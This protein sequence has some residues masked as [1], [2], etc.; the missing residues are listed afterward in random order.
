MRR[1]R[2]Y[3]PPQS[4]KLQTR[5]VKRSERSTSNAISRRND[6]VFDDHSGQSYHEEKKEEF[7]E[8]S[9][10]PNVLRNHG[11]DWRDFMDES[12][13]SLLEQPSPAICAD[14][15][16][17]FFQDLEFLGL[18][19]GTDIQAAVGAL[20]ARKGRVVVTNPGTAHWLGRERSSR[21]TARA[22]PSFREGGFTK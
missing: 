5:L 10:I 4:V 8:A 20:I 1:R 6:F 15:L 2:K 12:G 22:G 13:F 16:D 17:Y 9:D 3:P 21:Q 18:A 11:M 19:N 7:V 14:R